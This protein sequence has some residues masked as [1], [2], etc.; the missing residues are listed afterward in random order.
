MVTVSALERLL[1]SPQSSKIC[2]FIMKANS[3]APPRPPLLDS[4]LT[5]LV[6]SVCPG[7]LYLV[8]LQLHPWLPE[9]YLRGCPGHLA[10][11]LN[12]ASMCAAVPV[13]IEK[14]QS[15]PFS[16]TCQPWAWIPLRICAMLQSVGRWHHC[17]VWALPAGGT[18]RTTQGSSASPPLQPPP[19]LQPVAPPWDT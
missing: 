3:R 13:S 18:G 10:P 17:T 2:K 1:F 15:C 6:P 9:P 12:Q 7:P 14:K 4:G 19:C 5:A 16:G 8:S 11:G